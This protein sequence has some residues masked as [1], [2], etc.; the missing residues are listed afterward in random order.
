MAKG[1]T[2]SNLCSSVVYVPVLESNHEVDGDLLMNA[3]DQEEVEPITIYLGTT[4]SAAACRTPHH[5]P[6]PRHQR[7]TKRLME[8]G[9]KLPFHSGS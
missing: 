2:K 4:P 5:P 3:N 6:R 7:K 8:T 1:G 9:E